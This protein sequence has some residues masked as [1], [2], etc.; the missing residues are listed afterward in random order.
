MPLEPVQVDS[1]DMTPIQA[2]GEI[3]YL[4][5]TP[6]NGD[7]L[8]FVM[9]A[10]GTNKRLLCDS[11]VACHRPA[12]S[13]D[14]MKVAF[15]TKTGNFYVIDLNGQNLKR[16]AVGPGLLLSAWSPD[17][18]RIAFSRF[19][20]QAGYANI[21]TIHAD[22]TNERQLTTNSGVL[23]SFTPDNKSILYC[24]GNG[25]SYAIWKMNIDGSNKQ[26]LTP[27]GISFT[28]PLPS[29]NG[30]LIAMQSVTQKGSQIYVMRSD[31]SQLKQLTFSLN[32]WNQYSPEYE[33]NDNA[34]WSPDSKKLVYE[35]REN[36][37][38]DIFVINAD[39]SGNKRLTNGPIRDEDPVWT[40]D[41]Q[42]IV[43]SSNS[44][45]SLESEICIMRTQ[46][47]LQTPLSK[48]WLDDIYPI[49]ISK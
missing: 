22:G 9:K 28:A 46:G 21:Y 6:P 39:G 25:T 17:D 14:G 37:S 7:W 3:V 5:R 18:S 15:I 16:M 38:P 12:V 27:A 29:P 26:L 13:N 20:S 36:G 19:D 34:V 42:Y 11:L 35:C 33:N 31:G 30:E 43:F 32:P 41:G 23:A 47:Q 1:V 2:N 10:D 40:K 4:S 48:F 8:I 49:Y 45:G 24:G 44:Y